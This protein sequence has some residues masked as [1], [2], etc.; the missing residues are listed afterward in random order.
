MSKRALRITLSLLLLSVVVAG[1]LTLEAKADKGKG[2]LPCPFPPCMAP[3]AFPPQ[4]EVL[5]KTA[6]GLVRT[7]FACCCCGSAGNRYR[8]L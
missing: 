7:S 3:C 2:F 6:D 4:P 5:C 1:G 8:P